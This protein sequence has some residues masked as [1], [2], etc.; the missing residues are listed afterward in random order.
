MYPLRDLVVYIQLS[1][2][3][4]LCDRSPQL[5]RLA[6]LIL[7]THLTIPHLTPCLNCC[8]ITFPHRALK[9]PPHLSCEK[10]TTEKHSVVFDSLWPPG[11]YLHSCMLNYVLCNP[12]DCSPPGSSIHERVLQARILEWV[13]I[14][15][16]RRSSPPSDGTQVSCIAGRFFTSWATRETQEYWSG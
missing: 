16:S 3:T 6:K 12:K 4:S 1:I 9:I 15:F 5:F 7:C 13:A 11:L 14:P 10:W 2:V 8:P